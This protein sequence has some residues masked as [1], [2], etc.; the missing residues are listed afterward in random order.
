MN[1]L[2]GIRVIDV[3]QNIAGP[4]S[5]QTLAD[6]GADV[7]KVESPAGDYVRDMTWPIIEGTSLLHLHIN[8][9]KKSL[10]LDLKKP[11]AV[12][13][14]KDLVKDAD[15]VVEAMRPGSLARCLVAA[16]E[17]VAGWPIM[18]HHAT[19]RKG[20]ER[21]VGRIGRR[22]RRAVPWWPCHWES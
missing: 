22:G 11:E 14:Y 19:R 8:R 4:H 15:A 13:I 9:G 16:A 2:Q 10:V 1:V 6:L 12:E 21:L 3:T 18:P 7:I 5:T 20:L 17:P